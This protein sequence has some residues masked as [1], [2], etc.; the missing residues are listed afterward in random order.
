MTKF[1]S[2]I[3]RNVERSSK[4]KTSTFKHGEI[5][6]SRTVK[7]VGTLSVGFQKNHRTEVPFVLTDHL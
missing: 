4:K 2:M 5:P 1:C 3:L 7:N 6:Y